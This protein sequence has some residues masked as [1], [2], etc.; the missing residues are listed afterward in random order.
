M[1]D[2]LDARNY[3]TRHTPELARVASYDRGELM[4][5]LSKRGRMY[6]TENGTAR[7]HLYYWVRHNGV[8]SFSAGYYGFGRDV[9]FSGNLL[10]INFKTIGEAKAYCLKKDNEANVIQ[11]M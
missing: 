9:T 5:W 10:P 11:A 3:A 8:N 4:K 2:Y 1:R 6:K 7:A